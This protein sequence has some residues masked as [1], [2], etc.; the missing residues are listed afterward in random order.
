MGLASLVHNALSGIAGK[1]QVAIV[2]GSMASGNQMAGSDIDV[3]VLGDVSMLEIVKALS[4]VQESLGREVNPV[5]MT[6][7]KFANQ[8][9]RK[10]RFATRV[11]GEP[12]VIVTGNEH[13]L[14][15]LVEDRA[16]ARA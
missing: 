11:L 15:K 10:D 14:A 13:D 7:Q 1:I 4:S 6:A 16:T 3:C 12:K 2:F 5:V 8:V 9:S